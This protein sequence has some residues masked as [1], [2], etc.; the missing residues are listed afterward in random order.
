MKARAFW[1]G[2][3]PDVEDTQPEPNRYAALLVTAPIG[4]V[5]VAAFWKKR[6][7][8]AAEELVVNPLAQPSRFCQQFLNFPQGVRAI[9]D[10]PC[11]T[12]TTGRVRRLNGRAAAR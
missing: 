6:G 1:I 4:L 2:E 8:F 5:A 11:E 10:P 12:S 7:L 9:G 3:Y